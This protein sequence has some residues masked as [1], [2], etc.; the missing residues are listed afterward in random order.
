[1]HALTFTQNSQME[2]QILSMA[3]FFVERVVGVW[4]IWMLAVMP[5]SSTN[6]LLKN[7]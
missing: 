5:S 6:T 2:K 7:K 4:Y 3:M 1:M